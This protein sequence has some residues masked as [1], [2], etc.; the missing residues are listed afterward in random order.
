MLAPA[1]SATDHDTATVLVYH[2]LV[3]RVPVTV[4]VMVGPESVMAAIVTG[5]PVVGIE[6]NETPVTKLAGFVALSASD[7]LMP[8]IVNEVTP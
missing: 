8:L 5:K 3:P 2:P 4:G 6:A 7:A 1:A